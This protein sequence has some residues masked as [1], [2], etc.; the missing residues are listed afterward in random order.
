MK[1]MK[2]CNKKEVGEVIKDGSKVEGPKNKLN[3]FVRRVRELQGDPHYVAMGMAIGV[4]VGVTPTIPFHTVLAIAL[5]FVLR[6]SKP[7]AAIG[8]WFANPVTIPLFYIGS[9]KVGVFVFGGS[10]SS[11]PGLGALLETLEGPF[12]MAQKYHVIVDF[13]N[14]HFEVAC[15][16][17]GG[18]VLLGILPA[19]ISYFVTR[20]IVAGTLTGVKMIRCGSKLEKEGKDLGA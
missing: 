11:R 14:H 13:L 19:V 7:A 4:F 5:A 18:G 12:T 20:K 1:V 10:D 6:G 16:M 3:Q 9:Y 8:V 2:K 17:L 15:M